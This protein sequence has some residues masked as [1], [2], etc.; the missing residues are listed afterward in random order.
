MFQTIIISITDT[1]NNAPQFM[2]TNE[3]EFIIIPPLPPG[4]SI[5]GCFNDI[6]VRDIDLTT[7][8]IDFEIF[9]SPLF[10]ISFDQVA[11]TVPKQFKASLRTKSFIRTIPE[12]IVFNISAT[13][14]L[15]T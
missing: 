5:T 8:R 3:F 15:R 6:T 14:S 11:S 9:E 12:P 10:E 1:N 7:E 4:F 2:P 13:V